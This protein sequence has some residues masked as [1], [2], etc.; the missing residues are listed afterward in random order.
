MM[1]ESQVKHVFNYVYGEKGFHK[2]T[3]RRKPSNTTTI[4][5]TVLL[6]F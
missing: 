6:G 3:W 4:Y 5:Y 1:R 2:H